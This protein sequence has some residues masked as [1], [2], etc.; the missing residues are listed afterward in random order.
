MFT[1]TLTIKRDDFRNITVSVTRNP[2]EGVD[3]EFYIGADY[4]NEDG[5]PAI[6]EATFKVSQD[7]YIYILKHLN[8]GL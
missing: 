1:R 6:A 3:V 7:E 5:M 4:Y 2:E 8:G